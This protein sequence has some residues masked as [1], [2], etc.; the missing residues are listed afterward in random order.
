MFVSVLSPTVQLCEA[1]AQQERESLT[2]ELRG[3]GFDLREG[4]NFDFLE[5]CLFELGE[6]SDTGLHCGS[7]AALFVTRLVNLKVGSDSV[8]ELC[9]FSEV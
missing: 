9:S 7:L 3:S 4:L 2:F 8:N 6:P 1:R 5:K